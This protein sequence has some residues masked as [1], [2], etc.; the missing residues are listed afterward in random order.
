VGIG[1]SGLQSDATMRAS[2]S[3]SNAPVEPHH[4]ELVGS[5][6]LKREKTM[7][8]LSRAARKLGISR[9]PF[10]YYERR[11]PAPENAIDLFSGRWICDLPG[12][13]YGVVRSLFADDRLRWFMDQFGPLTGKSVL[14]LGPLEGAHT[15]MLARAGAKVTAIEGN[16]AAFLRCLITK[17]IYKINAEFLLGDFVPFVRRTD[18]KFD[19]VLASGV[20][21]HMADP[22]SLLADLMRIGSTIY[23]WSH[24][25]DADLMADKWPNFEPASVFVDFNDRQIEMRRQHY[26][27]VEF[28][29]TFCGGNAPISAW[30]T[31][32]GLLAIFDAGGFDVVIGEDVPHHPN[33]PAITLMASRR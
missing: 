3:A 21:Y 23:V 18:K 16:A 10:S 5:P 22:V 13:G 27:G 14:E 24:Y 32:Q 6:Q 25:F 9:A 30:L 2:R 29:G 26:R 20:L 33:G 12:Y 19:V 1:M 15:F 31:K 7:G 28:L 17:E 4:L 8:F 11:P